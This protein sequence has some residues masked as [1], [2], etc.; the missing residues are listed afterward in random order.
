MEV[1]EQSP[2]PPRRRA[3]AVLM[4]LGIGA[5]V[6]GFTILSQWTRDVQEDEPRRLG[7]VWTATVAGTPRLFYV[8]EEKRSERGYFDTDAL[9]S[10]TLPYSVFTLHAR[11]ARDGGAAS[12]CTIATTAGGTADFAK[13]AVFIH[14]VEEPEILGP[15]GDVLW[16]WKDGLEA[17]KLDTLEPSW[18]AAKLKELNPEFG[19]FLPRERKYYK[20]LGRPN[21]LTFKGADARYFQI[22]AASGKIAPADEAALARQSREHSKTADS[23][24]WSLEPESVSLWSTS[25]SGLMWDS[26]IDEASGVWYGLLSPDEHASQYWTHPRY[27][28]GPT[29]EVARSLYRT[30]FTSETSRVTDELKVKLD[31][32]NITKLGNERFL[33]GGFLRRPNADAIWMV[34]DDAAQ[35]AE[36]AAAKTG[37]GA[38][39]F[40]VLHRKLLGE[41]SPWYISR[42]DTSGTVLW[43]RSTGL[44]ELGHLCDGSGAAVFTGYADRSQPTGKRPDL[45]VFVDERTGNSRILNLITGKDVNGG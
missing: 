15:Q 44:A 16:M 33:Q 37:G 14:L 6:G 41:N 35:G 7:K 29:G 34:E 23:A 3:A 32:A 19:A 22:D 10:Y 27:S 25:P 26:I 2:R 1:D 24:F 11:N 31:V 21:A 17:R 18:S 40:L 30:S 20:V 38:K 5:V 8:M 43:T 13:R 12:V 45:M 42:I 9:H 28:M 36:G 4:V 39:S